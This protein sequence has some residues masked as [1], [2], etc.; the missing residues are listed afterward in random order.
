MAYRKGELLEGKKL[1]FPEGALLNLLE[2]AVT[3]SERRK[4]EYL[5]E[6]FV[7]YLVESRPVENTIGIEPGGAL[8]RRYSEFELLRNYLMAIYPYIVMPPLPEKRINVAKFQLAADKFDPDFI[9]RRRHGLECFLLRLAS[10]PVISQDS[11]FRGF[12]NQ[13]EGWKEAVGTTQWQQKADGRFKSISASLAIKK[14]DQRFDDI[15]SYSDS[16]NTNISSLQKVQQR[17]SEKQH[18]ILN[19]HVEY[20]KLFS[21][22]SAIESE[23]GDQLQQAGHQMDGLASQTEAVLNEEEI[24]YTDQLREYLYFTESLRAIVRKQY[25][26]QYGLER[27]EADLSTKS[28]QKDEVAHEITVVESGEAPAPT[29]LTLKSFSTMIFGQETVEAK[30]EKLIQLED[31]VKDCEEAV[32]MAEHDTNLFMDKSLKDFDRFK[33]QKVR[34]INEIMENYVKTQVKVNQLGLQQWKNIREY[35][36]QI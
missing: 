10:H 11:I 23:L 12:L 30:Q 27:A 13:E 15:R 34:D 5:K 20:G 31:Q 1:Y 21:E 22:W 4:S 14:P 25:L 7:V 29:G 3:E 2:V 28:R 33:K 6:P 36:S 35:F 17:I 24:A 32:K 26:R 8:W 18:A 19:Q 16:L 9:E